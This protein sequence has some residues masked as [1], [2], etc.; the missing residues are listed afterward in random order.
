MPSISPHRLLYHL[1]GRVEQHLQIAIGSL[2]NLDQ[3]ILLQ[4]AANGGWSIAQCLEH[5]N[6]YGRYYLPQI[7]NKIQKAQKTTKNVP[8][9]SSWLGKYFVN[10]MEPS[11][12][13]RTYKAF[14]DHI[15]HHDLDAHKV[16][17]EFIQQQEQLLLYLRMAYAYP[18][19]S[20]KIPISISKLIRLSLGDIFQFII[21]HNERHLQQAMRNIG[22]S[23]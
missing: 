21:A 18:L 20:I 1:E 15:P 6:S 10:M 11:K 2:Q 13:G 17:A 19:H 14:K 22:T 7:G 3:S 16:V 23:G 4:A 9:R 5:L 8:F 12:K